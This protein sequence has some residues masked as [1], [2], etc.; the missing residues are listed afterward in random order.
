MFENKKFEG[1]RYSRFIA[2]WY[3]SGGKRIRSHVD[4]EN[5][6]NYFVRWLRQ[7]RVN[8]LQ[9]PDDVIHDIVELATIGKAELEWNCE[10]FLK[11]NGLE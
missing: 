9:I 8:G 1:I 10:Y 6:P 5:R 7:L 4:S 3:V 2:S 11:E